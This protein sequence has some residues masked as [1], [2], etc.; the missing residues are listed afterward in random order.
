MK[1]NNLEIVKGFNRL[2]SKFNYIFNFGKLYILTGSNG[3]GKT[4]LLRCICGF[5]RPESGSLLWNNITINN[6][7]NEYSKN[8]FYLGHLDS[9][10]PHLSVWDNIKHLSILQDIPNPFNEGR[11]L[12]Q[13]FHLKDLHVYQLSAGQK[14]RVTLSLL[15][16]NKKS[17]WVLDEPLSSVDKRYE[18]VFTK[19]IND[20]IDNNGIVIMSSHDTVHHYKKAS[21]EIINLDV[22]K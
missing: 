6:E 1:L 19:L 3:I 16:L 20:H 2:F 18:K 4:T 13:I 10:S 12:F 17:L 7:Y 15:N 14:R 21:T 11:D 22:I 5:I 9:L 8:I